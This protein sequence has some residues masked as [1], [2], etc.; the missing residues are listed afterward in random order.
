M[1]P[2]DMTPDDISPEDIC[3]DAGIR[4]RAISLILMVMI[5]RVFVVLRNS[6]KS[7]TF[8]DISICPNLTFSY[9][10][11]FVL[12]SLSL[13]IMIIRIQFFNVSQLLVITCLGLHYKSVGETD[14]HTVILTSGTF[15]GYT[16]ILVGL[17]AGKFSKNLLLCIYCEVYKSFLGD[18]MKTPINKRID[19]FFSIVECGLFIAVGVLVIK[20]WEDSFFKTERRKFAMAKGSLS[21]V[22][23]VVFFLDI[24][25]TCRA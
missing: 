24:I 20:E 17:A 1:N 5:L 10:F 12:W 9:H 4:M 14:V 23:G 2:E 19:L 21:I 3:P 13:L 6:N 16:V 7:H 18:L 15:L 22:N 25:F 8:P 11:L